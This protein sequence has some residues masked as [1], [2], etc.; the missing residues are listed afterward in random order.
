VSATTVRHVAFA[1]AAAGQRETGPGPPVGQHRRPCLGPAYADAR[2]GQSRVPRKHHVDR[3]PVDQALPPWAIA[4]PGSPSIVRARYHDQ[5]QALAALHLVRRANRIPSSARAVGEQEW[6]N[7]GN[8]REEENRLL[9]RLEWGWATTLQLCSWTAGWW[10][11]RVE[12]GWVVGDKSS[13]SMSPSLD[14]EAGARVVAFST[15]TKETP[16]RRLPRW[17]R[18]FDYPEAAQ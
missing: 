10:G 9:E 8:K 16:H 12:I 5:P 4:A 1:L 11:E 6:W 13:C 17:L 18:S 2:F 3:V 15:A 7:V 14:D